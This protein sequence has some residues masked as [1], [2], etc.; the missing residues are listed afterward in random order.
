MPRSVRKS[1]GSP[2]IPGISHDRTHVGLDT[3]LLPRAPPRGGSH[4]DTEQVA[5]DVFYLLIIPRI[6][7][8][9]LDS[10][11]DAFVN[12]LQSEYDNHQTE[13]DPEHRWFPLSSAR[14]CRLLIR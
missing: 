12:H 5:N 14:A 7:Q 11:R 4:P 6:F 8:R 1:L 13:N 3:R 2:Q 9:Q 10:P